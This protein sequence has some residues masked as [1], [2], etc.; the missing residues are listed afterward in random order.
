MR[1]TKIIC[2]IGPAVNSKEKL[3]KL[4]K[5]G[6]NCARFNFSH[7][8]HESQKAMMDILKEARDKLH[9]NVPILLDTK[10]PEIRLKDF[11]NGSIML[12]D[13]Q[14]FTLDDKEEVLGNEK[15]VAITYHKLGEALKVGKIILID[16]GKVSLKVIKVNGSDVVTKVIHGGKLSNHKSLNVP[17]VSIPM[18]YL[19]DKD[20]GDLLF[21]ISQGIDFVAASFTRT[22]Q[23]IMDMRKFLDE[24]GGQNIE[25]IAKIENTEGVKNFE[26]ILTI[27][28]GI[29]VARGDLGVE[30]HFKD[31]P[32]I[33]KKIIDKC[34]EHG[35]LAVV[36]TQMLESMTA[37]PRPTRAEVSDV[38]NA[39]FD[40]ASAIMLSGESANGQFPFEAVKTMS[41]IA[42]SAERSVYYEREAINYK[43]N[44]DIT[45]TVCKAAFEA[46]EYSH[47]K[48]IVVLS[49]S[50]ATAKRV[51]LYKPTVPIIAFVAEEKGCRQLC[52]YYGVYPTKV[53]KKNTPDQVIAMGK[54]KIKD[55]NLAKKGDIIVLVSGTNFSHGHTDSVLLYEME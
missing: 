26:D 28:N 3:M 24:N 9:K 48:A 16:D 11:E 54:E 42:E 21:G 32:T 12:K 27:A 13:G 47:A 40:G 52:L 49:T 31:I 46:A 22:K 23:D 20:K 4:I 44:K 18:P 38:A 25:I 17:N 35:K 2:T 5:C 55:L 37:S 43:I 33:Q 39:V 41:A 15:R 7:G 51:S 10:G 8:T 6:M 30:I 34:N 53:E 14:E 36:A 29:M 19:S 1:K 50:G 45:Q